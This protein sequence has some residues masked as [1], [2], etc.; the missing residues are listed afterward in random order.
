MSQP[1]IVSRVCPR[2]L[3]STIATRLSRPSQP[4]CWNASH[5][6]PS[7]ISESPHSTHTRYGSLSRSRPAIARP[8]PTCAPS[9]RAAAGPARAGSQRRGPSGSH[10]RVAL[11]LDVRDQVGE[12]LRELLD[13]LALERVGDVV[14]V[15]PRL[16]EA[17]EDPAG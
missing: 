13:A 6:E 5:I 9:R 8:T 4:A 3:T 11:A 1:S 16:L 15:D 2:R 14:V 17:L 7:A 10:Q 12:R